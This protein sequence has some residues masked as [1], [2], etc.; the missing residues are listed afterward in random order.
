MAG[1]PGCAPGARQPVRPSRCGS[2]AMAASRAGAGFL[3]GSRPRAGDHRSFALYPK[4]LGGAGNAS[5]VEN[6]AKLAFVEEE[7]RARKRWQCVWCVSLSISGLVFVG[8]FVATFVFNVWGTNPL[9][10]QTNP[11]HEQKR[12]PWEKNPFKLNTSDHSYR[13]GMRSRAL[14]KEA[15]SY[16][17]TSL[18]PAHTSQNW[19]TWL[20]GLGFPPPPAAVPPPPMPLWKITSGDIRA[21]RGNNQIAVGSDELAGIREWDAMAELNRTVNRYIDEVVNGDE[22]GHKAFLNK[23]T[24]KMEVQQPVY[25]GMKGAWQPD[26]CSKITGCKGTVRDSTYHKNEEHANWRFQN[27]VYDPNDPRIVR[28]SPPPPPEPLALGDG[29]IPLEAV[30]PMRG[31]WWR[32]VAPKNVDGTPAESPDVEQEVAETAELGGREIGA[33]RTPGMME[34]FG[35]HLK[36]MHDRFQVSMGRRNGVGPKAGVGKRRRHRRALLMLRGGAAATA[37]VATGV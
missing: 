5:D 12:F 17:K 9:N 30:V 26:S 19:K 15:E 16:D 1:R 14:V 25:Q 31:A 23:A 11:F 22:T 10:P 13:L 21:D 8:L 20:G 35:G 7:L 18:I 36:A 34:R 33:P 28:P 24:G 32:G 4:H 3:T 37:S 27:I 6:M 2:G 29:S